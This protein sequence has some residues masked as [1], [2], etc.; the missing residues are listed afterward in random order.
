MASNEIDHVWIEDGIIVESQLPGY[1]DFYKE[2]AE[3][4]IYLIDKIVDGQI[5]IGPF[6]FSFD[7]KK[8][9]NFWS[10]YPQALSPNEIEIFKK[11]FPE[12]ARLKPISLVKKNNFS[13]KI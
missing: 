12:I 8:I 10:D 11:E 5:V 1:S 2:K 6:L 9:Y 3:N 4:Q 13:D 7:R